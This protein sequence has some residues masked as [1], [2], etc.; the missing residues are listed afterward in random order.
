MKRGKMTNET[1]VSFPASEVWQVYATLEL[2]ELIK[3]MPDFL[4]D[5]KVT[6]DGAVGTTFDLWNLP[7]F[8]YFYFYLFNSDTI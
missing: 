5:I 8:F 7:G 6:G 3:T 1:D 2:P 4:Q